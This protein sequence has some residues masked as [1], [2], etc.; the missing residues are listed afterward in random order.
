MALE[1]EEGE[2]SL[3]IVFLEGREGSMEEFSI[4]IPAIALWIFSYLP[5][6]EPWRALVLASA[7]AS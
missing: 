3:I 7:H 4:R 1:G 6:L 5:D 2:S